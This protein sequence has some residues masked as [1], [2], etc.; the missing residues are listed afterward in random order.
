MASIISLLAIATDVLKPYTKNS[1]TGNCYEVFVLLKLL[2][3]MGLSDTDFD[4]LEPLFDSICACNTKPTSKAKLT[5][6]IQAARKCNV[7]TGLRYKNDVVIGLR[8]VTQDDTDG[9]TADIILCL[10][11]GTQVGLSIFQGAVKKNKTVE[12]CLTNPSFHRF[13][14]TTED[15]QQI[16]SLASCAVKEY[17][18]EMTERCGPEKAAWKRKKSKA[19]IQACTKTACLTANRFNSLSHEDKEKTMRNLLRVENDSK[20]ADCL[21]VVDDKFR[22]FTLFDILDCTLTECQSIQLRADGIYLVMEVNGKPISKTQ[23][24]FNNGIESSLKSSW[25]FT[26]YMDK[27]FTLNKITL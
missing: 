24:K 8:N 5:A 23:V 3:I 27:V 26:C 21:C 4:A 17:N 7:G 20:P 22:F 14:C 13:G 12:K 19:A 16:D 25:N 18:Q 9:C 1:N 2:R 11:S 10:A 6:A 15:G